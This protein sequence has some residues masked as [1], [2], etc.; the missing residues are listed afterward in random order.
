[1]G[2]GVEVAAGRPP[3][4]GD[5]RACVHAGD[6]GDGRDPERAQFARRDLT[7]APKSLDREGMEE[8]ELLVGRNDEE[9][10]GLRDAA[11]H[12]GEELRPRDAD[13]D[14]KPDPLPDVATEAD[15]DL[16]RGAGDSLE[17]AHVEERFVDREALDERRRIVEDAEHRLARL[18]VGGHA[19]RHHDR[20]RA[21]PARLPAAHGGADAECLGLVARREDDSRAD[22]HRPPAQAGVV[23]LLNRRVE[24]V[25]VG[26]EDRSDGRHEHMFAPESTAAPRPATARCIRRKLVGRS[27][28]RT[29]S[30]R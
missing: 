7:D 14:R 25:D 19:G 9:A 15:G 20:L 21:K 1:V 27:A 12:L 6:L 13:R 11:R 10:V 5:Q 26:V 30:R 4:E 28:A 2:E 24:R 3:D 22:D 16:G 18:G 8:G 23:P 17:P 29:S